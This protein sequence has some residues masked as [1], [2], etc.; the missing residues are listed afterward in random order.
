MANH[1]GKAVAYA[2][3]KIIAV[4]MLTAVVATQAWALTQIVQN[5]K[6]IAANIPPKWLG[7]QLDRIEA[8]INAHIVAHAS[9]DDKSP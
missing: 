4:V 9:E 6:D 2:L 8:T 7:K 5:G 3:V 1:N